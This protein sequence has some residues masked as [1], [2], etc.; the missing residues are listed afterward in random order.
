M[1]WI[2]F[3]T[4]RNLNALI[5]Y[6][7]SPNP[8][9]VTEHALNE[10]WLRQRMVNPLPVVAVMMLL[11]FSFLLPFQM[12]LYAFVLPPA[13]WVSILFPPVFIVLLV[14]I[15]AM[16]SIIKGR[17]WAV[18]AFKYLF[19]INCLLFLASLCLSF[20]ADNIHGKIIILIAG[21]LLW[22]RVLL[23][24]RS[25]STTVK[26]FIHKKLAWKAIKEVSSQ[27]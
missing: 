15:F 3:I 19:F 11:L 27:I 5:G 4:G 18:T 14:V 17:K 1:R 24:S 22:C 20:H 21:M 7:K 8:T 16:K 26:F 25:F 10:I 6:F 13:I 12:G 2:N 9:D 23:N